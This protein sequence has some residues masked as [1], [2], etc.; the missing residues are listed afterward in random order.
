MI[1]SAYTYLRARWRR[2][3]LRMFAAERD[4]T[5]AERGQE[6]EGTAGTSAALPYL[7][8]RCYER[9]FQ[10]GVVRCLPWPAYGRALLTAL[11][12]ETVQVR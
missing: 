9:R 2:Q 7:E 1:A 11:V 12:K 5:D 6:G 10:Q 3:G 8:A 4:T